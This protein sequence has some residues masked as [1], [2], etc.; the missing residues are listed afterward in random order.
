MRTILASLLVG[1]PLVACGPGKSGNDGGADASADSATDAAQSSDSAS[2]SSPPGDGGSCASQVQASIDAGCT[3]CWPASIAMCS[4][5]N[6][7]AELGM[8]ACLTVGHCWSEFDYNTAGP[9][10]DSVIAQYGDASTTAVHD[11]LAALGCVD[12][13]TRGMTAVAAE[14]GTADRAT[15]AT[16]IGALTTCDQ[17]AA[18]ACLDKTK[19]NQ[20]LCQN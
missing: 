6:A 1:L 11:K 10:L 3:R 4:Q 13:F 17:T 9:C 16:C 7:D 19:W 5:G 2:D 8:L 12:Y 18:G 14:L 15:L 20:S